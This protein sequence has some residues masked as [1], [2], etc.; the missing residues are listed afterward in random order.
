M[1]RSIFYRCCALYLVPKVE[2]LEAQTTPVIEW[3]SGADVKSL[4]DCDYTE[5]AGTPD[6]SQ[7]GGLRPRR[8]RQVEFST[9]ALHS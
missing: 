6:G 5:L 7:I 8:I 9:L 4:V 3:P 1:S 2:L